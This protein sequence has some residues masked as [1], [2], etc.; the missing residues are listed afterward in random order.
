MNKSLIA[1]QKV[2]I[3]HNYGNSCIKQVLGIVS[4]MLYDSRLPPLLP[5]YNKNLT[6][7]NA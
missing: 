6:R 7:G 2:L 3:L 4:E 5:P 1:L